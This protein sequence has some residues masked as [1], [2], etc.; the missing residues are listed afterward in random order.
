MLN[1]KY[2]DLNELAITNASIYQNNTPFPNIFFDDFFDENFL[3]NVL[4]EF[5]DLSKKN[6]NNYNSNLEKNKFLGEGSDFYGK[7]TEELMSY[8]NS[9]KF[10]SFLQIITGI[11]QTLLPDPYFVGGGL[12]ETKKGGMLKLHADFNKHSKTG[13]DRRI[14]V[15]I[16]LNKNWQETYG[17]A[18]ELWDKTLTN[19]EEKLYPIFNRLAIFST[20]D[21]SFHGHPDPLSCP[22]NLSR[23]S[24][25]LYYYSNGRP[26][27][28]INKGMENHS[29]LFVERKENI[30]DTKDFSKKS[31]IQY[32]KL[33][34][35]PIIFKILKK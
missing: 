3:N 22:E 31:L 6:S 5:P 20:T 11:G 7:K 1:G 24:I 16:Y 15:L 27:S 12:H 21:F 10:L 25:A 8:L 13:L 19:C 26:Q 18:F 17:G 33:F 4:N 14:N 29:T 32:I 28:E 23:K 9:E 35:P 30:N 2:Q 34:L